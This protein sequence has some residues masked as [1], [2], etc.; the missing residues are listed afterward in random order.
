MAF[1]KLYLTASAAPITV[2]NKGSWNESNVPA[3]GERKLSPTKVGGGLIAQYGYTENVA[4]TPLACMIYRGVS[5]PLRAQT[6]D[7]NI[8]VAV[9]S[10]VGAATADMSW[11]L[12]LW[13]TVGDTDVVR[14][15]LINQY[16]EAVG[17]EWTTTQI[18]RNLA[19]P[20]A[21][22]SLGIQDGDRLVAEVGV[23][24]YNALSSALSAA[25][26]VGTLKVSDSSILP[27][28]VDGQTSIDQAPFLSFSG[29]I[30]ELND[31]IVGSCM[32]GD[33][34]GTNVTSSRT[35][36]FCLDGVTRTISQDGALVLGG[37]MV[38]YE[39]AAAPAAVANAAVLYAIDNGAGKTRLMVQMPSGA[40][41]Q[42]AVEA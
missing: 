29:S 35:A 30:L 24:A 40:A 2:T 34:Q 8:D 13:V 3:V 4:T 1:T 18:V 31:N 22:T 5:D 11:R 19:A 41:I 26:N 27:D 12:H 21:M 9:R 14:G 25:V 28:A 33:F 6:V 16:A 32:F 15:T 42:L 37:R 10:W 39:Q 17:E 23:V 36:A 20:Q 7:G 38:V